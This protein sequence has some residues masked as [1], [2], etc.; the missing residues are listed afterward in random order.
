MTAKSSRPLRRSRSSNTATMKPLPG[1]F[2][3]GKLTVTENTADLG[4]VTIAYHALQA[5]LDAPICP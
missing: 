5:A 2:V 3:N 1:V 4:G